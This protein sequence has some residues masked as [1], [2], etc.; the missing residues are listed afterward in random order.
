MI[1]TQT[2]TEVL[3]RF[4]DGAGNTIAVTR[5]AVLSDKDKKKMIKE[6]EMI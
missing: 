4:F 1:R 3:M 6:M 2:V 5:A